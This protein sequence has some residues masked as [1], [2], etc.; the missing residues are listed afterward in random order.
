MRKNRNR[1]FFIIM[2]T[3]ILSISR[4]TFTFADEKNIFIKLD[5][6]NNHLNLNSIL[7]ILNTPSIRDIVIKEDLT[8]KLKKS[9]AKTEKYAYI[10]FD[11]GLDNKITP[12]VLDVLKEND[13]K[14]TFFII[15]NTIKKNSDLLN[16]I[17]EEGHS[18]GNHTYSHKKEIL[19]TSI[20]NFKKELEETASYIYEVTGQQVKLFRPPYGSSVI[21]KKEYVEALSNYKVV[22]WNID[23]MDSR[24]K[25]ITSQ[26]IADNVISSLKNKK[27]A[28]ILFHI[29]KSKENTL[30]ALPD[31][32][33]YLKDNDFSIKA[34]D[35]N[36]IL[37]YEYK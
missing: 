37:K 35:E 6:I 15:G 4:L 21:K 18:I 28:I 22:M 17:V 36:T 3:I 12:K 34:I 13:I 29:G 7:S 31:V 5:A 20:S 25:N 26:Q 1:Y 30:K 16:R 10:T 33:K 2:L 19:Y 32:I 24:T 14:A 8:E 11:D 9:V 23:S 27:N